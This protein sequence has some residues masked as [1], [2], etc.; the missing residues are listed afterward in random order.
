MAIDIYKVISFMSQRLK[1]IRRVKDVAGGMD[2]SSDTLRK[3][4]VRRTH[5]S[6]SDYLAELRINEMKR[7]LVETD[8]RCF[9]ICFEAGFKREDT[10]SRFFKRATGLTMEQF[11]EKSRSVGK[12]PKNGNGLSANTANANL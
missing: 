2:V 12:H 4:F 7:R 5:R 6:F 3:E 10:G 9:E 1:S 8:Q 11:R